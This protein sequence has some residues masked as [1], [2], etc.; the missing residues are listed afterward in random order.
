[1]NLFSP[2]VCDETGHSH[3]NI[4]LSKFIGDDKRIRK[5][6]LIQVLTHMTTDQI[7]IRIVALSDQIFDYEIS[8]IV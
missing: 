4:G 3:L 7:L 1:M 5:L 8:V 6:L 2:T